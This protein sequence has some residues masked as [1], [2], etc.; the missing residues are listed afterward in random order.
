MQKTKKTAMLLAIAVTAVFGFIGCDDDDSISKYLNISVLKDSYCK[1]KYA[2]VKMDDTQALNILLS[3]DTLFINKIEWS[4]G[5]EISDKPCEVVSFWEKDTL[6]IIEIFH[7]DFEVSCICW[8][9]ISFAV[10]DIKISN[11]WVQ[12]I[13]RVTY[14]HRGPRYDPLTHED[15]LD[16][17]GNL[18]IRDTVY[19]HEWI[20]TMF[21]FNKQLVR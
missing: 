1:D 13:I 17:H 2:T 4:Y 8:R 3:N 15:I 14:S 18:I 11:F 5:C 20:D 6:K 12:D 10:S 7:T 9:D 16:E 21:Y 19:T